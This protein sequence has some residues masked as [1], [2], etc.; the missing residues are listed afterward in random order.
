MYM[1]QT[2]LPI[3]K[4]LTQPD[5]HLKRF[6]NIIYCIKLVVKN[7]NNDLFFSLTKLMKT[8]HVSDHI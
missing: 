3:C 2:S 1:Q 6:E 5:R 7:Y 8:I 4:Y